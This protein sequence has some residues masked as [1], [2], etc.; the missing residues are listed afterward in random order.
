MKK[1]VLC[2][3]IA[4]AFGDG[5]A[6]ELT[7]SKSRENG[8]IAAGSSVDTMGVRL[9]KTASTMALKYENKY[10][11]SFEING[12]KAVLSFVK[13]RSKGE[14]FIVK[15]IFEKEYPYKNKWMKNVGN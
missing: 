13:G 8:I 2:A 12:E 5:V 1:V 11:D 15:N 7:L 9:R 6:M 3:V 10:N 14:Q 4:A